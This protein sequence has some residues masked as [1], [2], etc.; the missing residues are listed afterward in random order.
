MKMCMTPINKLAS[1]PVGFRRV[2]LDETT[3]EL[4]LQDETDE[5]F[6]VVKTDRKLTDVVLPEPSNE[7]AGD[8]FWVAVEGANSMLALNDADMSVIEP[9]TLAAFVSRGTH[10]ECIVSDLPWS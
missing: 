4:L 7:N 3:A 5:R 2:E 8:T 10:W 1:P 6:V 9:A